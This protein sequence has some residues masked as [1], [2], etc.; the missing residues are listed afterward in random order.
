MVLIVVYG[1]IQFYAG[2]IGIEHHLGSGWAIAAIVAA[3]LFRFTLPI[4]VG[5]FFGAMNVWEWH[6][7]GALVFAAPGLAFMAL[8]IPGVLASLLGKMRKVD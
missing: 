1:L 6:W 7:A 4:T 3:L 5:S 8:M 2:W